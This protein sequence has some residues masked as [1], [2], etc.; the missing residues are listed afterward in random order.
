[1]GELASPQR[2]ERSEARRAW[3]P[4]EESPGGGMDAALGELRESQGPGG[5]AA[6]PPARTAGAP[7]AQR[8][9]RQDAG[10]KQS[11]GMDAAGPLWGRGHHPTPSVTSCR[12]AVPLAAGP[13]PRWTWPS[14]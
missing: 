3:T 9:G 7:G 8:R 5:I 11:G 1:M 2:R 6:Q 4:A 10:K 14:W 12:A 13:G